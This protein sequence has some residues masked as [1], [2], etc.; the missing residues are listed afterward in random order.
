MKNND[1]ENK[2]VSVVKQLFNYCFWAVMSFLA[3]F[4]CMR[5]MLGPRPESSKGFMRIFDFIYD[6]VMIELVPI[7]GGIIAF[8][9]ILIDIVYLK[10]KLKN[11]SKSIL[12]RFLTIIIITLIVGT[13]HYLLEKVIDII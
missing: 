9:Y 11:N 3:A 7:I 10:K 8:L 5:I 13:T 12:L 2:A 6:I 4:G 1:F